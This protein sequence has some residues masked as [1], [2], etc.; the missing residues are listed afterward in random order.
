M[1]QQLLLRKRKDV[2][3]TIMLKKKENYQNEFF[4]FPGFTMLHDHG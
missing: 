4:E 1:I 3:Y 2:N